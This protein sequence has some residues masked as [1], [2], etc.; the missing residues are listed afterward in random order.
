M[1]ER[2]KRGVGVGCGG[3]LVGGGGWDTGHPL[4]ASN[5]VTSLKFFRILQQILSNVWLINDI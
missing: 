5:Y 3:R 1:T 4:M 2:A